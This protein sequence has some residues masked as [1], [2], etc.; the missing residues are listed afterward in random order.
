M[1]HSGAYSDHFNTEFMSWNSRITEERHLAEITGEIGAA[2]TDSMNADDGVARPGLRR[3]R[4]FNG[5]EMAGFFKLDCFHSDYSV[6]D[7]TQLE[8]FT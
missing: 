6:F 7:L 4:D 2:N 3:F 8:R 5:A 1:S